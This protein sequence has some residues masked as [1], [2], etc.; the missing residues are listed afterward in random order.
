MATKKTIG[1]RART[2]RVRPLA[3]SGAS[4]KRV[5]VSRASRSVRAYRVG[6][7]V[8]FGSLVFLGALVAV[9][10]CTL[11][12]IAAGPPPK[13]S[14][15]KSWQLTDLSDSA[16]RELLGLIPDDW[17]NAVREKAVPEAVRVLSRF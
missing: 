5:T 2:P 4:S 13:R 16:R 10:A 14:G 9:G 17:Q 6:R 1:K 7:M 15:R 3:R 8:A 11:A 12:V